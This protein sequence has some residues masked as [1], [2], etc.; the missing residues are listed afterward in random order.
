MAWL[1]KLLT[2]LASVAEILRRYFKKQDEVKR[3][4]E[5]TKARKN[6]AKW[7][8][9]RFANGNIKRVPMDDPAKHLP[10]DANATHRAD[11]KRG[12]DHQ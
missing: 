6:P 10:N 8:A 3:E 1:G 4:K 12:D 5:I 11:I 2:V 7:F 9:D